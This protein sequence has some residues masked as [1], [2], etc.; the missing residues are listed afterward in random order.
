MSNSKLSQ[1]HFNYQ[2]GY[3]D[4]VL[5]YLK[6]N[7]IKMEIYPTQSKWFGI[8]NPGDEEIIKRELESEE[9]GN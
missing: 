2:Y 7:K 1:K 9:R 6:E 5:N 8:T 3:K 4:G